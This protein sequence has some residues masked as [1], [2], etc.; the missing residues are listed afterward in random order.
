MLE[1]VARYLWFVLN[2]KATFDYISNTASLVAFLPLKAFPM[3]Q[4][5]PLIINVARTKK[6]LFVH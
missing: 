1:L 2:F 6:S 3:N 4:I 5:I